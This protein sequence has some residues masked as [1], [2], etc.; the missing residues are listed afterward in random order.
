M[1]DGFQRRDDGALFEVLSETEAEI[2]LRAYDEAH[3]VST[4]ARETFEAHF[5]SAQYSLGVADIVSDGDGGVRVLLGEQIAHLTASHV[6]AIVTAAA[7]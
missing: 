6:A 3:T 7:H 1:T 2:V 4:V 5:D